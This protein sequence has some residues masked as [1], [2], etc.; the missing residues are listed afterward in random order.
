MRVFM[1][2]ALILGLPAVAVV[3]AFWGSPMMIPALASLFV[4]LLP[5][6]AGGYLLWKSKN[7]GLS[8]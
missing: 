1:I 3:L 2:A 8:E 7:R 4:V 6:A 5:F